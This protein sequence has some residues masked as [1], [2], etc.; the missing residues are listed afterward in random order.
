MLHLT[1]Q[2]QRT[3]KQQTVSQ[4]HT[5][6][7]KFIGDTTIYMRLKSP[8]V[9]HI[10]NVTT[11]DLTDEQQRL[12]TFNESWD[13]TLYD[14]KD[15]A[16]EGFFSLSTNNT[17]IQCFSCGIIVTKFPPNISSFAIHLLASPNCKHLHSGDGTK[18]PDSHFRANILLTTAPENN[19]LAETSATC[20]ELLMQTAG[21]TKITTIQETYYKC[22]SCHGIYKDWK[23]TDDPWKIHWPMEN[24]KHFPYCPH[25]IF[26]KSKFFIKETLQQTAHQTLQ[27]TTYYRFIKQQ[28]QCLLCEH[29][30]MNLL[31]VLH[32]GTIFDLLHNLE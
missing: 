19:P 2:R 15:F 27:Y 18:K 13:W 4:Y 30:R 9:C 22:S 3:L 11:F 16:D 7:A 10:N 23:Q 20:N 28:L 5:H 17:Y 1:P 24:T 8:Y 31:L 6:T 14:V 32:S 12:R 26:S 25:V 21:F 29:L